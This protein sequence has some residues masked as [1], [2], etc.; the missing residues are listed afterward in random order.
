MHASVR[1][2]LRHLL[3]WTMALLYWW[4]RFVQLDASMERFRT[5]PTT[6]PVRNPVV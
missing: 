5:L 1:R 6:A 3:S 4:I 2:N